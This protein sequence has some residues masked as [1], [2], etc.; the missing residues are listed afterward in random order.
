MWPR[1]ASSISSSVG[2]MN[3]AKL[4]VVVAISAPEAAVMLRVLYAPVAVGGAG[5]YPASAATRRAT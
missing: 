3:S 1:R 5:R 4:T 2:E